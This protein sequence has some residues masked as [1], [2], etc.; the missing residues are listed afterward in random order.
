MTLCQYAPEVVE[1]AID[2][3][4]QGRTWKQIAL[5]LGGTDQSW[6]MLVQRRAEGTNTHYLV[7]RNAR[8][9]GRE[10]AACPYSHMT[11]DGSWWLA[12]W[13]DRDIEVTRCAPT[14]TKRAKTRRR[15]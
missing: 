9:M 1:K 11:C 15:N 2:L 13:N 6:R 4:Q 7:G 12:G 8:D 5:E 10:K 3:R 14:P